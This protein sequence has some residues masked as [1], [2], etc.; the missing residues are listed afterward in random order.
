MTSSGWKSYN[1]HNVKNYKMKYFIDT[2]YGCGLIFKTRLPDSGV[3]PVHEIKLLEWTGKYDDRK[4]TITSKKAILYSTIDFPTIYPKINDEVSTPYGR[5]RVINI[6]QVNIFDTSSNMAN[7]YIV[8]LLSWRLDGRSQV[9]CHLFRSHVR[10]LQSKTFG[11]MDT[12]ERIEFSQSE[13]STAGKEFRDKNYIQALEYYTSAMNGL[14]MI[15]HDLSSPDVCRADLV[16]IMVTCSNNAATCCIKLNRWNEAHK[17]ATN[18][19]VIINALY[20]RRGLKV[21]QLLVTS[22][23]MCDSKVFGEWRVKS[24]ILI[25]RVL[26]EREEYSEAMTDLKKA[27][28]IV[29]EYT[30]STPK[31]TSTAKKLSSSQNKEKRNLESSSITRLRTQEREIIKITKKCIEKKK[32]VIKKQ[33]SQAKAMF[34]NINSLEKVPKKTSLLSS[35]DNETENTPDKNS[36]LKSIFA[37][38]SKEKSIPDKNKKVPFLTDRSTSNPAVNIEKNITSGRNNEKDEEEEACIAWYD[39]HKEAILLLFSGCILAASYI[40]LR[41]R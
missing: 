17:Y 7:K 13:K 29:H 15:E 12:Y 3:M 37:S 32:I 30:F 4:K 16:D 8:R 18:A 21:H 28:D 38:E 36:H 14:R 40:I 1:T 26:M 34:R 31:S 11:E 24:Y 23:G 33:K 27:R 25:S 22:T 35:L 39:E 41:K 6:T 10:V 9:I 2:P 19:L 5:G 20:E